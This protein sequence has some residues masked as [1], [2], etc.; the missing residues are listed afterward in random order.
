MELRAKIAMLFPVLF[1]TNGSQ[2]HGSGRMAKSFLAAK[3]VGL[4]YNQA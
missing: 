2:E 1:P 4:H 3:G